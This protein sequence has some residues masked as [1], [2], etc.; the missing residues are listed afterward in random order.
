[1]TL[2][3]A[4]SNLST[5]ALLTLFIDGKSIKVEDLQEPLDA[6]TTLSNIYELIEE[7]Y[8]LSMVHYLSPLEELGKLN[9]ALALIET[10]LDRLDL[11][12]FTDILAYKKYVFAKVLCGSKTYG[13]KE[14][15][16]FS[17]GENLSSLEELTKFGSLALFVG[18]FL[19][20]PEEFE[21][22][23]QIAELIDSFMTEDA[24]L[25]VLFLL[26]GGEYK[27]DGLRVS[28]FI[29]MSLYQTV[30][31]QGSLLNK[32]HKLDP[33]EGGLFQTLDVENRLL[34]RVLKNAPAFAHSIEKRETKNSLLEGCILINTE[35][36][37]YRSTS[38]TKIG[39]AS[40]SFQGKILIPSFGPHLLPLGKNDT[41]GLSPPICPDALVQGN[42]VSMWNRVKSDSDYGHHW[43]HSKVHVEKAKF[44]IE[45]F[46][47]SEKKEEPLSLVFFVR[48]GA[49]QAEK[50][51]IHS[52]GLERA[53]VHTSKI[54]LILSDSRIQILTKDSMDVE[55]IPLGGGEFFF[56]SDFLLSF[57]FCSDDPLRIDFVMD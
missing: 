42:V 11:Q 4:Q 33:F 44:S 38:Q 7:V 52:G 43:I 14:I 35:G 25:D 48:A 19:K 47:W 49:I 16:K 26:S 46:I 20:D 12:R 6:L 57:P 28:V 27:K 24:E 23:C 37:S 50:K 36:F 9:S 8:L 32:V 31:A 51:Q 40:V 21:Q 29:L 54:V 2:E 13:K 55:I 22:G 41:Y 5:K 1:M 39:M 10:G 30:A 17:Y 3:F 53:L 18:I 45:S 56:N 15:K 34:C